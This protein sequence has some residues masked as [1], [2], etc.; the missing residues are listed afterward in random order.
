MTMIG[1]GIPPL[2]GEPDAAYYA[3]VCA[4]LEPPWWY[5]WR[6]GQIGTPGYRPMIWWL[7]TTEDNFVL[8][9]EAAAQNPNEMFLLGNEPELNGVQPDEAARAMRTWQ[10][11]VGSWAVEYAACGV[12]VSLHRISGALAWLDGYLREGGVVPPLWHVHVY[13]DAGQFVR[14]LAIFEQW[15]DDNHVRR[16][17]IVSEFAHEIEYAPL[18]LAVERMIDDGRLHSAA[19]FSAYYE[20]WP[21][22]SLL[23]AGG[24]LTQIGEAYVAERHVVSLPAV[25]A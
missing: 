23:T 6:Y 21:E 5:D 16:P 20:D 19:W 22:P 7:R 14:A 24:E 11:R 15:M 17:V 2:H 12:N 18:M 3:D 9:L 8:G 4:K 13:G 10:K 25:M 1:V